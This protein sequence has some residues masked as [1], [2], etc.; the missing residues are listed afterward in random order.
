MTEVPPQ[1][2]RV[3]SMFAPFTPL[4][5]AFDPSLMG[6]IRWRASQRRSTIWGSSINTT[7]AS[8]PPTAAA[9]REPSEAAA[10]CLRKY[11]QYV[12]TAEATE[13]PSDGVPSLAGMLEELLRKGPAATAFSAAAAGRDW[14][15]DVNAFAVAACGVE[16]QSLAPRDVQRFVALLAAALE[17]I[18]ESTREE[19]RPSTVPNAFLAFRG[20]LHNN[21]PLVPGLGAKVDDEGG[22]ED[23]IGDDRSMPPPR[24]DQGNEGGS[25]Q[26]APDGSAGPQNEPSAWQHQLQRTPG[27]LPS[28]LQSIP[29]IQPDDVP[30]P[31]DLPSQAT[32]STDKAEWDAGEDEEEEEGITELRPSLTGCG[33]DGT[34]GDP[35]Q[36]RRGGLSSYDI[37]PRSPQAP[38]GG[39]GAF[40]RPPA[41]EDAVDDGQSSA[42][43]T[44]AVAVDADAT[45]EGGGTPM[46]NS[47]PPSSVPDVARGPNLLI[48]WEK[49]CRE[50]INQYICSR[51][52]PLGKGSQGLVF[53]AVEKRPWAIKQ[54]VYRGMTQRFV[55]REVKAMKRLRHRH[56][57]RVH[58][59]IRDGRNQRLY[60]VMQYCDGG[61]VATFS[62]ATAPA[63]HALPSEAAPRR[64]SQTATIIT[65]D[66]RWRRP[67]REEVGP[68]TFRGGGGAAAAA[69][70][71][72]L[73]SVDQRVVGSSTSAESAAPF[74]F[75]VSQ[76]PR[77]VAMS[78]VD[79]FFIAKQLFAALT[80]LHRKKI[81]HRDI[82]PTNVLW[83][84]ATG[85][86]LLA[87]FGLSKLD[88]T[89]TTMTSTVTVPSPAADDVAAAGPP[90]PAAAESAS[91]SQVGTQYFRP[92]GPVPCSADPIRKL[93]WEQAGDV[94]SLG[95]TL[96]TLAT[97]ALP[98]T[99]V[100]DCATK[101]AWTEPPA[102]DGAATV[103]WSMA[104]GDDPLLVNVSD[105][106][107]RQFLRSALQ[108]DD[109]R[110]PTAEALFDKANSHS[111]SQN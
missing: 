83:I 23:Q 101:N 38:I 76:S 10:T 69:P 50:G 104:S 20:Q 48:E 73:P 90:A 110:R 34:L 68:A 65:T 109:R 27:R 53:R 11:A 95:I 88:E 26:D 78:P 57:V 93:A 56:I 92:P 96:L 86:V 43:V 82:K 42:N 44:I 22:D 6:S 72:P 37:T 97:G 39:G 61:A 51:S 4:T 84:K 107:V 58:E 7:V 2:T 71:A 54:L 75:P 47:R 1:L 60:I 17:V 32:I 98:Y 12:N 81:V 89:E 94:W 67:N 106:L 3:S 111:L 45:Q 9:P 36:P 33:D 62:C 40:D 91:G 28:P 24:R 19:D 52:P 41:G 29:T 30:A 70:V 59:V 63:Y 49:D 105:H 85:D 14:L 102:D 108:R 46:T 13:V 35:Q 5:L 77:V 21:G 15:Q 8:R 103:G 25:S 64:P 55:E 16:G 18:A 99:S 31:P 66:V 79:F 100:E 74:V 80:F 87:D